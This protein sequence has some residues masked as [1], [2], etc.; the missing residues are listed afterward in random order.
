MQ[1]KL[2]II[3]VFAVLASQAAAGPGQGLP[4]TAPLEEE[5]DLAAKMV[6]GI[7]R[8]LLRETERSRASRQSRWQP[9]YSSAD[10]YVRSVAGNRERFRK[11]TGA[12]DPRVRFEAPSLDA[13]VGRPALLAESAAYRVFAVRWPVLKGVDAE[14]LLL[15][16]KAAPRAKVV[17]LPDADWTPESIAGVDGASRVSPFAKRLAESG[18]LVLIPVLVDRR[19]TWSGDERYS[20]TNQT[21]REFLYRMSYQM[22]RHVIGYEIQKVLAAVDWFSTASP[23]L[24]IGVFGYG[25][26]GLV[27]LYSA[28]VD[29]RIGSAAVSGYFTAREG[30][31]QEPL[32]RNVWGLL[33]EFG[34]AGIARLIA[35]RHL[36]VEAAKSPEIDGP[37]AVAPRRKQTAAPG[38]LSTPALADVRAEIERAREPFTK[39]GAP[40]RLVL[41]ESGGGTGAPGSEQ[42]LAAFARS[43]GLSMKTAGAAPA[44]TGRVDPAARMHRQFSQLVDFTQELVARS[45]GER[46]RFWSKANSASIESW[47][48]STEWYRR[49]LWDEIIGRLPD[50]SEPLAVKTR[51]AYDK[52]AWKGYDVVIPVWQDVFAYGVLMLPRDLKAGERRPVVVCQ[53]GLE[54]TP[55]STIDPVAK[56]DGSLRRPWP[57]ELA[58]R[59]FIVYVP[60]NPYIGGEKFRTVVR[61]ANPLHLTLFSFILG[62]HERT[63]DWLASLPYVDPERIGFY[64]ISYGGKTAVRVPPLLD[65]YALSIC[66][67]DFNEWIR[68]TAGLDLASSYMYTQEYEIYEFNLGDTFN[69]GEMANLMAPRPFMVERG[70]HDGVSIDE[71]VAYEYAKVRRFYTMLGLSGRTEI[72]FFNGPHT[73]HGEGTYAFLHKHL[74]WP[75]PRKS[76]GGNGN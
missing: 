69:H 58:E 39:L 62:Q 64:G 30:V 51:L 19:D 43:L 53:H 74:R 36:I 14:G 72:E 16:P 20:F 67:G 75:E 73:I 38:R 10:A 50:A 15:E 57:V 23:S 56:P 25:E 31:W 54:G 6:A 24:P 21:H 47:Q 7:D 70:H 55:Q 71:W 63:L 37:P 4:G 61:K 27:A 46:Q 65:R 59:G 40:D 22:G 9:D 68:K 26:G 1:I 3:A 2:R 52:P 34:D 12:V 13:A 76:G 17:A 33:S 41:I 45:P 8:Y 18:C 44:V 29:P 49:Y 32:Y 11:I 60:Q 66:S 42:A 28:A 35:P 5:G 48:S